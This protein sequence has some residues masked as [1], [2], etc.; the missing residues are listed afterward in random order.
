MNEQQAIRSQEDLAANIEAR[1][2]DTTSHASDC[3]KW[4]GEPCNCITGG[5]RKAR[6]A[7]PK[8]TA[9]AKWAVQANPQPLNVPPFVVAVEQDC[10]FCGGRGD[11]PG[12]VDPFSAGEPCPEC[13]GS[14]KETVTR[15]YLGEAFKIAMGT[16]TM[17]PEKAHIVATIEYC[18][19]LSSAALMLPK[20]A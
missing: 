11:D 15:N 13:G 7:L 10:S 16:G 9:K 6:P 8:P 12:N 19:L 18:R 1:R 2:R 3:A 5:S 20:V 17:Q 4:V 14:K